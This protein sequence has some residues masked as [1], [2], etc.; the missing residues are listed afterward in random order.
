VLRSVPAA[1]WPAIVIGIL[2]LAVGVYRL[3]GRMRARQTVVVR[4]EER[5]RRRASLEAE[6]LELRAGLDHLLAALGCS[7]LPD[8]EERLETYRNLVQERRRITEFLSSL[9]E[10]STDEAIAEQWNTIRRDIFGLEERLREPEVATKR[11]TPLQ[12]QTLEREVTAL[13]QTLAQKQRREMKLTVDLERLAGDAEQL[14]AKDEQLQDVE[15]D[16]ARV[17][18]HLATCRLALETLTESRRQAEIPVREIAEKKA[19]E[20]LRVATGGRYT[21][22]RVE[23]ENLDL[24]VWSD[25][26]GGWVA[27]E[28]PGV[29]RGTVDLIYLAVRLSLVEVLTHGKRPPL[30]FDDPFITFDDRRREGAARLL[31]ELSKSYQVILFTCSPEYA[32]YADR[33]ITIADRAAPSPDTAGAGAAAAPPGAIHAAAHPASVPPETTASAATSE[34]QPAEPADGIPAVGPLWERMDQ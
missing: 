17:R 11:L 4:R 5:A 29:S 14:V 13:E 25:D 23:G 2:V 26:A 3:S 15:E 32:R 8:A 10:G 1:A 33:V 31:S 18:R 16:L 6:I 12:V 19:G 21:R 9:R 20:Y 24:S 30:L 28:E 7:A 27:A 22:V 34:P